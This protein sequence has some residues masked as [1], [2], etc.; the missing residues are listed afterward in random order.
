MRDIW[1]LS[2]SP[3]SCFLPNVVKSEIAATFLPY[4]A[5][6]HCRTSVQ[7]NSHNETCMF[8][9]PQMEPTFIASFV[10]FE[11][12]CLPVVQMQSIY[13]VNVKSSLKRGIGWLTRATLLLAWQSFSLRGRNE[14]VFVFPKNDDDDDDACHQ[15]GKWTSKQTPLKEKLPSLRL[16]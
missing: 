9:S 13:K 4:P 14:I 7:K 8:T 3:P 2:Q 15:N 5:T 12:L 11:S 10:F 16:D 6:T 1:I